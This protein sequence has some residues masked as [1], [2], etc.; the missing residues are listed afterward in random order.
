MTFTLDYTGEG[1]SSSNA[2][3]QTTKYE[4]P[5]KTVT[6]ADKVS[7]VVLGQQADPE[8]WTDKALLNYDGT[9]MLEDLAPVHHQY[10]VTWENISNDINQPY[11]VIT[12]IHSYNDDQEEFYNIY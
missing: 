9:G 12:S 8:K 5:E 2:D 1:D 4:V 7:G 10:Q 3:Q 11:W 6:N